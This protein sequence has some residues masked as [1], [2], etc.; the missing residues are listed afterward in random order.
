MKTNILIITALLLVS[1]SVIFFMYGCF[2]NNKTANKEGIY[3]KAVPFPDVK[4][5]ISSGRGG[6]RPT[7]R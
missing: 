3:M 4:I 1:A 2:E 6:L 7:E 5:A